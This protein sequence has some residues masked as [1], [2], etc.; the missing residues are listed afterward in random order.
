MPGETSMLEREP[1]L[2]PTERRIFNILTDGR[3]HSADNLV[4]ELYSDGAGSYRCLSQHVYNI[5]VKLRYTN[6][7]I[8]IASEYVNSRLHYRLAR[9]I[10]F[11]E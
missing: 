7:G 9:L 10:S 4:Q 11:E 2:T 5:K 1:T 6:P 8:V 3:A